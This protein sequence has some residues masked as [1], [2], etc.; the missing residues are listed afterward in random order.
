MQTEIF[1]NARPRLMSVATRMLGAPADA[2]EAVQEAW[3]R[4]MDVDDEIDNPT[5]WLTTVVSRICLDM[6]RARRD[7]APIEDADRPDPRTGP[8]DEAQLAEA[9]GSAMSAV[10]DNLGPAE[11]VA[12][13]LHD[14]FGVPFDDVASILGKSPAATRQVASRARKRVSAAPPDASS[15]RA[16]AVAAFLSASRDGDFGA[17]V[18]L[19]DPD[20]VFRTFTDDEPPALVNGAPAIAEAFMFRAKSALT[21]LLDGKIGVAVPHPSGTDAMLLVMDVSFT[22]TGSIAAIDAT[23]RADELAVVEVQAAG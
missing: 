21:V 10:I 14:V 5:A 8:A 20:A 17:L 6:L 22:P 16:S 2:E 13:V 15:R 19:L 11:R 9:V 12:F 18:E 1:E 23:L 3:L 4:A 7:T